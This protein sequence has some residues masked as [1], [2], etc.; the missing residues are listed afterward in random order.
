MHFES[1]IY[2]HYTAKHKHFS[3]LFQNC[4]EILHAYSVQCRLKIYSITPKGEAVIL[5]IS[6]R[7]SCRLLVRDSSPKTLI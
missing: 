7:S 3:T 1:H 5:D 4:R 2:V 6:F